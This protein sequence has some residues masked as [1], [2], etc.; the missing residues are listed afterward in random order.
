MQK[1][2]REID[3]Y[4]LTFTKQLDPIKTWSTSIPT[5]K[6]RSFIAKYLVVTNVITEHT[7]NLRLVKGG[8]R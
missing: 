8:D 3:F 2:I 6:D 7:N 4:K 1:A 5:I